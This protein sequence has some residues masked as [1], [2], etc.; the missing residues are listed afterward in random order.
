[1]PQSDSKD[2]WALCRQIWNTVCVVVQKRIESIRQWRVAW[3]KRR[4]GGDAG[5]THRVTGRLLFA[6]PSPL[7]ERLPLHNIRVELWDRDLGPDDF[8][9]DGVTDREGRFE[10]RYDPDDAGWN[11]H[12]DLELRVLDYEHTYDR[13]RQVV[14]HYRLV[15]HF[16]GPENVAQECYDFGDLSVAYWEYDPEAATPRI[17]VSE[18]GSLPQAYAPGRATHMLHRVGEIEIVKRLHLAENRRNPDRPTLEAIQADYPES[19]TI[20]TD[21]QRPGHSRSDEFFAER[22]LNGMSASI[23]DR[24][25]RNP[26]RLWLHHHWNSY[27]QDDVHAMPNVDVWFELRDGLPFPVE[28]ALQF[29]QRGHTEAN[30]PQDAPL[31]FKPDDGPRWEQ[32]K[33][34]ARVSA[35]LF[36]ELDVHFAQTHLNTEQYAIPVYRNLRANPLRYLLHPHVKEVVI[37]NHEAN[38]WLLGE[39]GYITQSTAF[40]AAS[41][42]K[43]V[44]QTVGTLDWKNWQPRRALS[45][46]HQYA[47]AANLFWEVLTEYVDWFF[48]EHRPRIEEHWYEV[49]RFSD[50][51]VSHSVP[52]FLCG[53]LRG[54]SEVDPVSGAKKPGDWFQPDERIDFSVPRA[55]VGGEEKAIQPVTRSDV[56]DHEGWEN[57]KQLCRYVIFHA[58]FMHTW[59]NS[60]QYDDGGELTYNGLGL[61]Y[62]DRGV[63]VPETDHSIAPP[64]ALAT[65]QLW[66]AWLLSQTGYGYIMK[67][68]EH[69]VHPKLVELL[70]RRK[71]E[72]AAIGIDI[73]TIQSR[74]NI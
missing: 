41:I 23:L 42:Q 11:D 18:Q 73:N 2:L 12:P 48:D 52:F 56:C 16:P 5:K 25:P 13:Q 33:R 6:Y 22:I 61:R 35:A 36:A 55:V 69:D 43:R 34:V 3:A 63:L 37:I 38:T 26:D 4:S 30:A 21:R 70:R 65:K 28:I 1:M 7:G 15:A 9:G 51:L 67:N 31:H 54:C 72:F 39:T 62:G 60:R 24:D 8:L 53:F 17:H 68:E 46:R 71:A 40:T 47:L 45:P 20:K 27:E 66:F 74:T 10:I 64:P 44:R 57:M 14:L 49:R 50:D 32:A 59:S 29:R 19:L 58:T